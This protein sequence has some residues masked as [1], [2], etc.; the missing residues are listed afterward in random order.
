MEAGGEDGQLVEALGEP[1]PRRPPVREQEASPVGELEVG[2]RRDTGVI[3]SYRKA[4][5]QEA[6]RLDGL[7]HQA[8]G[9]MGQDLASVLSGYFSLSSSA[10]R[11]EGETFVRRLGPPTLT[12]APVTRPRRQLVP[13]GPIDG[14][15]MCDSE[16]R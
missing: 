13:A 6:E 11:P 7:E 10:P 4:G 8:N 1:E 12:S 15:T 9:G 3:G 2:S 5:K 14:I 16:G